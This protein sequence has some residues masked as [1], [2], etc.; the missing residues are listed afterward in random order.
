MKRQSMGY[1]WGYLLASLIL[2][3]GGLAWLGF[4]LI[5]FDRSV[6]PW[7]QIVTFPENPE[8]NDQK[9]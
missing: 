4:L 9:I 3:G 7:D 2:G 1:L 6:L 5:P 8:Q